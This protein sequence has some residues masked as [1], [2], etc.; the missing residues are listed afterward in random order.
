MAG[1]RRAFSLKTYIGIPIFWKGEVIGAFNM[2]TS[3]PNKTVTDADRKLAEMLAQ[4]AAVAIENTRLLQQSVEHSRR[5]A[6]LYKV[7]SAVS[8]NLP[9]PG[10][11]PS[12]GSDRG[13]GGAW[14]LLRPTTKT[15]GG[16]HS[17][18]S[19]PGSACPDP[20]LH[21]GV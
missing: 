4:Q 18:G 12:I 2:A 11:P 19:L 9:P 1:D 6:V 20:L 21:R 8:S 14:N 16:D 3:Q 7:V 17:K 10:N 5:Q 13:R 15:G